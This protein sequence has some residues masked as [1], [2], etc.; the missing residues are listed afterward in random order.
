MMINPPQQNQTTQKWPKHQKTQNAK[1]KAEQRCTKT[2]RKSKTSQHANFRMLTCQHIIVH[3][4]H[5]QHSIEK[6]S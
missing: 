3:N 1:K 6:Y 2:T 5:T 4:C